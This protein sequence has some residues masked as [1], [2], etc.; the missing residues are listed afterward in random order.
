MPT[1][2]LQSGRRNAASR[3]LNL[4]HGIFPFS[5]LGAVSVTDISLF[6]MLPKAAP[7]GTRIAAGFGPS[8]GASGPM[9]IAQVPGNTAGGTPIAALGADA[10]LTGALP[11]GS[12]TLVVP[13][14]SVPAALGAPVNGHL[15]LKSAAV[16]DVVLIVSYKVA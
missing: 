6:L 13:E 11:P 8:G 4:A 12:F 2:L 5:N 9:S 3:T 7:V 15:R 16:E 10:A 1:K 14:A